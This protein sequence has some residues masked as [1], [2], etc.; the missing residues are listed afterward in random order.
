MKDFLSSFIG[1]FRSAACR[2]LTGCLHSAH[3][4]ALFCFIQCDVT[5]IMAAPSLAGFGCDN[6]NGGKNS[7]EDY[8]G[9]HRGADYSRVFVHESQEGL[10]AVST[11]PALRNRWL[12][13]CHPP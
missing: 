10:A 8:D 13:R 5:L 11:I 3:L 1:F 12:S 7:D 4:E 9:L 2:R 6:T